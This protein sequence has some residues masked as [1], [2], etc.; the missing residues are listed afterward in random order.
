MLS[1]FGLLFNGELKKYTGKKI[2]LD[3]RPDAKPVHQRAFSLAKSQESLF[4]AELKHL[5]K[6]GVLERAGAFEWASP[7]FI[8]PKKTGKARWVSDFRKLN[9]YAIRKQFPLPKIGDILAKRT[10]YKFF[11]KLDILMQYYTFQLDGETSDL[12][13]FGLYRYKQLPMGVIPA[14]DIA[15]EIMDELFHLIE[16]C[17]VYINDVSVFSGDNFDEHLKSLRQNINDSARTWIHK[18]IQI[19]VNGPSKK[20][21]GLGID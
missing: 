16:K 21:I 10:G 11:T 19:N 2:T 18:S 13:P 5:V 12:T 1:K 14:P 9:K 3:V 6:S 15:Q 17:D 20:R 7:T 8:L 4:K